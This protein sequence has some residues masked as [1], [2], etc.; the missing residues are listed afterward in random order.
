[1]LG[2][3]T[4][5]AGCEQLNAAEADMF[6]GGLPTHTLASPGCTPTALLLAAAV[7]AHCVDWSQAVPGV[8]SSDI[9]KVSRGVDPRPRNEPGTAPRLTPR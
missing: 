3:E 6:E 2:T 5:V 4:S 1:M 7:V 8:T 9:G